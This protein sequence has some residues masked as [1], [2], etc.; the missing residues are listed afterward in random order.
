M[1]RSSEPVGSRSP[2][3]SFA[4]VVPVPRERGTAIRYA[5]AVGATLLA[6]AVTLPIAPYLQRVIFVLFW[7]AVIGAAWFGGVGPAVL[8]SVLSVLVADYFLIGP[9]GQLTVSSPEDLIPLAVF[10]FSSTA[11]ALL[12]DATRTARR[13]AAQAAARNVELIHELEL[14][15]EELEQQLE[16]SQALSE[17]L[18]QSTEEL[19]ER[20]AA[21][22]TAETFT[23][24]ILDSITHPFVVH[25]TDWRFRYINE[26]AATV[27]RQ[28]PRASHDPPIG[29]VL[30]ELYPDIV[31]SAFEREMRRAA[32]ERQPVTFEAFY[33]ARSEWLALSCFP[34]ADG[35]LATQWIDITARRR[36][37]E[38]DRYLTRAGQVLGSSLDYETTLGQLA[39]VVVPELADWCA[40]H[41]VEE[42]GVPRELAVA[43]VDP[44]KV[45]WA[46]EISRRY[47]PRLDAPTGVPNVL[48]T[49]RPEIYPNITDE[50]VVAGAVDE[51][52]LRLSRQL[53]LKSALIV[54][55]VSNQRAIGALTLVSAESGRRYSD[56]DLPLASELARRAATAVE[57][58]RLHRQAVTAGAAAQRAMRSVNRL[59]S[60]AARLTGAAT[61]PSVADAMLA[62]A[63]ET[64]GAERGTVSLV[65]EDGDT[66]R[67]VAAFGY[68]E[69]TLRQWR[70]YSLRSTVSATRESVETGRGVFIESLADARARYPAAAP[71][72]EA[73]GTETAVVLPIMTDGRVRGVLTLAWTKVHTIPA[74]E[75]EF[76]QRFAVQSG[77]AFAR[78]LAFEAERIARERTERL[79][80]LTAALADA[81]NESEVAHIVV[82]HLREVLEPRAVA[83]FRVE[84][85]VDH[86]QHLAMVDERGV[87]PARRAR[88]Q[89]LSLHGDSPLAEL[90]RQREPVFLPDGAAFRARFPKWPASDR[91]VGQEAWVGIPLIA[92]TGRPL[93]AF[94]LGFTEARSFD[95]DLRRYVESIGDQATQ[96]FERVRL[97]ETEHAARQAAEEANRAKTQ[98]LATMSHEL[99]T[100]LNAISGYAELLSL[101][102]RGPTTPEQQEDLS[103]IMRSQRHLLSVI[104]DIL[105]FARL[106][107]GHVEYRVTN[108]PVTEL[109][110]DLE[111]LIRPQLAAK[112]LEFVC[113]PV[114]GSIVARAD[115]EKV[116]QVLLNLLANA[117]KFTPPGGRVHVVCEHDEARVY[118]RVGDT[119]IGI[120]VD[121]RGAIFEPFVQLHRTLAQPA[122]GTGLGLAI[123][124]DLARGMGGELTVESEA[125]TGSTFTLALERVS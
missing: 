85:D 118:I 1:A 107:A 108:V 40:V 20:T 114:F 125:G 80:A 8:A 121:R 100:P 65:A 33:P 75:R 21:A 97:L 74:D 77:Q 78:A 50:M 83:I 57:H 41:I 45:A 109:L 67:A 101:G 93:G 16:E 116:R 124:R 7:P 26:A 91:A 122:E 86:R 25:D 4:V 103:R 28:S 119:G 19:A 96:A 123:S 35:G 49:A 112:Q 66:T 36:A 79:Q 43:H 54:P 32:T 24:G 63:A 68:A 73:A 99:R 22:E 9:P 120:P 11:V 47:P 70:S 60:L 106:E 71:F 95:T 27:F 38:A 14:Q 105:N 52:H 84:D 5:A 111:S 39:Q 18:E 104:N 48:R 94:A 87:D 110:G 62:E 76:M 29:R 13:T 102:L 92:S 10:L 2:T 12:T 51:E 59:Y 34:L 98:F 61:P 53:G 88:F 30:W 46:S 82:S 42:D 89:S 115:A 81:G 58:A 113:E 6:L 90:V 15:A 31:G 44:A 69:D 56:E 72:L 55:L 37:E 23:K 117:V 64:F 17:E 3:A